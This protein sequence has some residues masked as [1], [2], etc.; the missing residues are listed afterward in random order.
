MKIVFAILLAALAAGC[1]A[2]P[3]PYS[4]A[5]PADPQASVPPARYRSSVAG[6]VSRR[7]VEP[8]PWRERNDRVAPAPKQ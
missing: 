6:Y 1:A 7:P 3:L 2:P 5:D 8:A 4:G